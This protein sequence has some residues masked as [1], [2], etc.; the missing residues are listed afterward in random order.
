MAAEDQTAFE[1]TRAPVYGDRENITEFLNVHLRY[2][3][4]QVAQRWWRG[5]F[6]D[7]HELYRAA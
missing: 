1:Y 4:A 3:G 6:V 2:V 5:E 7:F